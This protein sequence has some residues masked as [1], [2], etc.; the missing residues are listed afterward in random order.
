MS[1]AK[2][3]FQGRDHFR[4][5]VFLA[6]CDRLLGEL[7]KHRTS[8]DAITANFAFLCKMDTM[9]EAEVKV[10]AINLQKVYPM[11]IADNFAEECSLLKLFLT[12]Y[13]NKMSL[14]Q[15]Y[16]FIKEKDLKEAFPYIE[17]ALRIFLCTAVTNCSAELSFSVLKRIKNYQ[18]SRLS[19][20][21]LN[22]LAIHIKEAELTKSLDCDS[23]IEDFVNQ[24]VH[25]KEI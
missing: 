25:R 18:R 14:R 12:S 15:L 2:E 19:E 23:V 9:S 1:V 8:Y 11:D 10:N 22:S 13:K 4:V 3:K 21:R 17:I 5:N 24:F 16:L 20:E 7:R 6:I